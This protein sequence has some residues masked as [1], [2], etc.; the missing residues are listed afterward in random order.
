MTSYDYYIYPGTHR[1][2]LKLGNSS[3]N[4]PMNEAFQIAFN[5]FLEDHPEPDG[6][7]QDVNVWYALERLKSFWRDTHARDAD[8]VVLIIANKGKFLMSWQTGFTD[9]KYFQK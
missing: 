8:S 9:S 3:T 2:F 7:I 1:Q 5:K 6:K 4:I